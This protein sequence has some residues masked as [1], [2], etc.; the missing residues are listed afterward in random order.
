MNAIFCRNVIIYFD[1]ETQMKLME[2]FCRQLRH[3]AYLFLGHS[4]TLNRMVDLP[5]RQVAPT[6]YCKL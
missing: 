5:L 1:Y 2:R 6:I 3:G 4:E